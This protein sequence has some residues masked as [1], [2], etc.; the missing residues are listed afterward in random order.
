MVCLARVSVHWAV[1]IIFHFPPADIV[2]LQHDFPYS[3]TFVSSGVAC[4]LLLPVQELFF[5]LPPPSPPPLCGPTCHL[6][7]PFF[8]LQLTDWLCL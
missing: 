5:H 1:Q 7:P 6:L 3:C 8:S 4:V 2:A